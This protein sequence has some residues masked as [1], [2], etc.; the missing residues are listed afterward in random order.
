LFMGRIKSV[1]L[2]RAQSLRRHD[3][4]AEARLW[5]VLRAGRL[6]GWKWK[7]QA[8]FGPYILDFLCRDAALVV[9]LDGGQHADQ[10][11]YDARRT[12]YLNRAGLRVIRFWN[13]EVLQNRDGV[14]LTLLDACASSPPAKRR[15][16]G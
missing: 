11:A 9:E 7:R 4:D 3:T 14:Y 2:H 13:S 15:G 1:T 8:P 10:I 16:R 6:D 5:N 12:A